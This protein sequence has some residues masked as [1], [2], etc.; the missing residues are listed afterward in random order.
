[1]RKDYLELEKK[2]VRER[3]SFKGKEK[4]IKEDMN[5]K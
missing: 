2:S 3:D 4:K 5:F 1:V